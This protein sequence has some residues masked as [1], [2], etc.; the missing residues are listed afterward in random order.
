MKSYGAACCECV[1]ERS[2]CSWNLLHVHTHTPIH[3]PHTHTQRRTKNKNMQMYASTYTQCKTQERE[4]APKTQQH[5]VGG[6]NTVLACSPDFQHDQLF[7]VFIIVTKY[8]KCINVDLA[9]GFKYV[10]LKSSCASP[11]FLYW[12]HVRSTLHL[13]W[14][15]IH[16]R[17]VILNCQIKLAV[18]RVVCRVC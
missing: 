17:E 1:C 5:G 3:T 8:L 16:Q 11:K 14:M 15:R 9:I 13:L 7:M 2:C 4:K 6:V 12:S 18:K 10:L